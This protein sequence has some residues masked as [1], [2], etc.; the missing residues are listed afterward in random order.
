[1]AAPVGARWKS[2]APVHKVFSANQIHVGKRYPRGRR[3]PLS[4]IHIQT[5][6][7]ICCIKFCWSPDAGWV[8]DDGDDDDGDDDG[9]EGACVSRLNT[10]GNCSSAAVLVIKMLQSDWSCGSGAGKWELG[11]GF[12][13]AGRERV[14]GQAGVMMQS[15]IDFSLPLLQLFLATL[16][17]WIF[18]RPI[19]RM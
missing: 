2:V 3:V 16:F 15:N 12:G 6:I 1:M 13:A 14:E 7:I 18:V 11:L 5:I 8:H 19:P 4:S 9:T 10:R 17:P